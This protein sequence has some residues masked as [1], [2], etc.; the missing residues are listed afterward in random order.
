MC[1]LLAGVI[2]I[3][4]MVTSDGFRIVNL[5]PFCNQTLNAD[6]RDLNSFAG[7]VPGERWVFG[8]PFFIVDATLNNGKASLRDAQVPVNSPATFVFALI[9]NPQLDAKLTIRFANSKT[10]TV[11]IADAVPAIISHPPIYRWHLDMIAIRTGQGTGDKGQVIEA[12]RVDGVELFALTLSTL[13][14]TALRTTLMALEQQ[15]KR[16]EEERKM[17]AKLQALKDL[18]QPLKGKVAVLPLVPP[19]QPQSH[20]VFALMSKVGMAE[21]FALLSPSQFVDESTF[22]AQRFPVAIYFGGERFFYTVAKSNDSIGA[23]RRFL[24]DGGLLL[25]FSSQPFPFY[26]D[27]SGK[28]IGNADAFGV[29]VRMGWERPPQGKRL[30]FHLNPNQDIAPNLP[31][32]IPFPINADQRWRPI[33]KPKGEEGSDFIWEPLLTL[34]DEQGNEYGEG[35]ALLEYRSGEFAGG[36]VVYVWHSLWATDAAQILASDLF[37]FAVRSVEERPPI[38]RSII[39]RTSVAIKIDGVLDELDWGTAPALELRDIKGRD[40]PKTVAKMLWD[41][42]NLYIAFVCDDTDIWATKTKRDDFLWEEEVV[43]IFID[44]DGDGQDYF[45]FQVNPLNTQ[46]DLLIPDPVVGVGDAKRNAQWDCKGWLSE[47]K[48]KGTINKRDDTDEG[49]TVEMAIPLS[50]LTR[51]LALGTQHHTEWRLNLYRID[52]PKGQEEDPLLLS[53][54]KCVRWFH[55]P[56]RFGRVEFAGNPYNDDFRLYPEGSDGR[57]TWKPLAGEWKMKG[58]IYYGT[59]GGSDAWIAIGSKLGFEWWSDYEVTVRFRVLEFGSD[60]RDGFWLAF[61]FADVRNSYSLNFYQGQG[62]VVHL[63]KISGGVSTEDANPMAIAKW[64]PDNEWHEVK[65]QVKG[66]HI[67]SWLDGKQLFAITDENFN[68]TP[69]L[70]RGAIIL[71][72]RKWTQGQGHTRIAIEG[73]TVRLL[74]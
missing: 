1:W 11:S 63:H 49:W 9:A 46:I 44:P 14:E 23:V 18:L 22:N 8:V 31:E 34:R 48:V 68:G 4:T 40:A 54:S 39:C 12:I 32:L 50:E 53:W 41:D 51:N 26:Y 57:P 30:T 3:E 17:I 27:Q 56:E 65:L 5:A 37:S 55:E 58:R 42:Q 52:R 47:V 71:S 74:R 15:R 6:W 72:P 36:R 61:R 21:F 67:A 69:P 43:E 60:W 13:D 38:A 64:T 16:W 35:A 20:P 24:N 10:Q 28:P 66:N 70:E 33:V 7:L 19:D 59:D 62:G 25:V 29:P 73:V 2:L 45:E